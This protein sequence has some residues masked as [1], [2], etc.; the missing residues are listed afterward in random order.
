M[1]MLQCVDSQRISAHTWSRSNL[2]N[3][4]QKVK[5]WARTRNLP[6]YYHITFLRGIFVT[7][8]IDICTH[9][10]MYRLSTYV[11]CEDT[12]TLQVMNC[13][14]YSLKSGNLGEPSKFPVFSKYIYFSLDNLYY[15]IFYTTD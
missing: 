1:C 7:I 2:E 13:E 10:G 6:I 9:V 15:A 4:V 12:V 5:F 11:N 3:I 14:K 8:P